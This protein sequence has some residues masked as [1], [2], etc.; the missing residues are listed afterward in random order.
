MRPLCRSFTVGVGVPDLKR[1][2]NPVIALPSTQVS[3]PDLASIVEFTNEIRAC[4]GIYRR[5]H[6]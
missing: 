3:P 6:R 1:G 5:I 4:N 2:W